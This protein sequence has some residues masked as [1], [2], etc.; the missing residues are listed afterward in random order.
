[1][2]ITL[3]KGV[4]L[5]T[6]NRQSSQGIVP[7]NDLNSVTMEL[8][9]EQAN[10]ILVARDKGTL[11]FSYNPDGQGSGGLV[12]T[13]NDRATLEEILGLQP[14]PKPPQPPAPFIS[15]IYR[16]AS[17]RQYEYRQVGDKMLK[18]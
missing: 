13:G 18:W 7:G 11:Y 6:I 17:R 1:M 3:F 2:T 15:Q 5:V 16:G 10:I 9:S 14:I 12:V 8:S 4:K